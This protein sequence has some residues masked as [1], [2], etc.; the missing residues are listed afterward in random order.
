MG[1]IV[2]LEFMLSHVPSV[3]QTM[4]VFLD[5]LIKVEEGHRGGP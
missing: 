1:G 2:S 4:T 5:E 3:P